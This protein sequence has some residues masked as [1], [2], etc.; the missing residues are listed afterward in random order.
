MGAELAPDCLTV[1]L[2]LE[3]DVTVPDGFELR[4]ES[5]DQAGPAYPD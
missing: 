4:A 5:Y 2:E 1:R 3:A